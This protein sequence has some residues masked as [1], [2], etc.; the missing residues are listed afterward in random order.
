MLEY[1]VAIVGAGPAGITSAIYLSRA[2]IN[3]C[4]IEKDTPGGLVNKTSIIENYLGIKKTSGPELAYKF[5]EQLQETKVPYIYGEVKS[6]EEKDNKKIIHLADKDIMA[7]KIILAIGRSPKRLETKNS[8]RLEGKGISFCSLCDGSL[9]K[10]EDVALVGAGN[11]ALEEALYL[12]DI[13]KNVTILYRGT[14]VR[15]D[16][17]L[18][19]RINNKANIKILYNTEVKEFIG[20]NDKLEE[21]ILNENGKETKIKVKACFIFIGYEPAT[22]FLKTLDILDE[23]GYINVDERGE[24]VKKG[25][26]AA[27]DV[28]KKEAYQIIT[29]A[30]D[31]VIASTSCIKDLSFE[32]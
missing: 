25:I 26:Y 6:I 31:A 28:V 29:A 27:G 11:S 30:S 17:I 23:K 20:E 16:K 2:N 10:N 3:C 7:K 22:S 18:L 4:I 5:Y 12:S 1:D 24:T 14:N 8:N 9:Y 32:E 21:L 19:E 13:C 15:G